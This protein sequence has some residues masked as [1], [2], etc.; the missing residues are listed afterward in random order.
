MLITLLNIAVRDQ[1]IRPDSTITVMEL[2]D[3]LT[4]IK[5]LKAFFMKIEDI[6]EHSAASSVV[7]DMAM[8]L[9]SQMHELSSQTKLN[10]FNSITIENCP[11]LRSS[12]SSK[13]D[14][15]FYPLTALENILRSENAVQSKSFKPFL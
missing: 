14:K 12:Q 5:A 1:F 8:E 6:Q 9:I 10:S 13:V 3:V 15:N 7:Q 2:A 4:K 11:I